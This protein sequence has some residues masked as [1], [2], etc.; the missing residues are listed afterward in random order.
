MHQVR[1]AL[2]RS[3]ITGPQL[4]YV[5]LLIFMFYTIRY[6]TEMVEHTA[7]IIVNNLVPDILNIN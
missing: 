1:H 5:P 3:L 6:C 2:L 7:R 4:G